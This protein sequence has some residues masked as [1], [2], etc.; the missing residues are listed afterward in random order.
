MV[1]PAIGPSQPISGVI[2]VERSM[3]GGTFENQRIG[4]L[5]TSSNAGRVRPDVARR[6]RLCHRSGLAD[7]RHRT[8]DQEAVGVIVIVSFLTFSGSGIVTSTMPSCVLASIFFGSTP[9]GSAIEREKE[10]KR[11]SCRT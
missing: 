1:A 6:G 10:P 3:R 9:A 2:R 8:A 7:P 11:R 5:S 4:V